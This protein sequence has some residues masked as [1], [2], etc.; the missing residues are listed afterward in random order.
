MASYQ[1]RLLAT[2]LPDDLVVEI[3]SRLPVRPLLRCKYVSRAWRDLI[4]SHPDHRRR[5]AQT[6]S[7]SMPPARP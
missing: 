3:L 7:T 4:I 2:T 6:I 5:L 1:W